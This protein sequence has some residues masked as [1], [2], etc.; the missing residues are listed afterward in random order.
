MTRVQ[1]ARFPLIG[2][3]SWTLLV[4]GNGPAWPAAEPSE[5]R[6]RVCAGCHGETGNSK[7]ERVPSLAGQAALFMVNQ[8]ILMREK[9]RQV[10]PM[11][12]FV[13]DLPDTEIEALAAYY[14]QQKPERS[15]EPVDA[16]LAA[17][18]A[19]LAE[20]QRCGTC[21]LPDYTG[22]EQIP[23]LAWQRIDYLIEGMRAYRDNRR[24]GADTSM[25]A[26]MYGVSD[27][28]VAALA[29]FLASR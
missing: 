21:H 12:P 24:A 13:E 29:H 17:K 2:L 18:G 10:E 4:A 8:L 14:A 25:N 22:R 20:A 5:E 1:R 26:V 23:R 27:G 3:V 7:L 16:A 6:L 9:I 28:D 11:A 15:D 19:Q